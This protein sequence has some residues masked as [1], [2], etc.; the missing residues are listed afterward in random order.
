[1]ESEEIFVTSFE[2]EVVT[3]FIGSIMFVSVYIICQIPFIKKISTDPK[4][5]F[6]GYLIRTTRDTFAVFL[7]VAIWKSLYNM[8]EYYFWSESLLRALMYVFMGYI[9][10]VVTDTLANNTAV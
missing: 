6:T 3:F 5:K 7:V 4:Y 8:F 2:T 1:M 9:I 10:L